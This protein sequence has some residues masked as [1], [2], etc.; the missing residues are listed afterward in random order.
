MLHFVE[1]GPLFLEEKI[2]EGFLPYMG[3]AEIQ[4]HPNFHGCLRIKKIH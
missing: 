3:L 1:I 2:F 4:T